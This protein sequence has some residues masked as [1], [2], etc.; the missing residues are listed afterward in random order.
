[1]TAVMVLTIGCDPGMMI[2]Q[3]SSIGAAKGA[4]VA[5]YVKTSHPLIGETWYAPE[6]KVTN[7]SDSSI[8]V[9]GVELAARSVI[10]ANK[11]RRPGTYPL[12]VPP[13]KTE[14]LDIWFD[15]HDNVKKTFQEPA[16]LR[17]HYQSSGKEAIAQANLTGGPLN[18]SAP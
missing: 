16:E 14:A 18:T 3:T 4:S 12:I 6:V 9:T 11:P 5:V 13:G 17:V 7:S 15:L 1:M 8:A 10:Y 2:R